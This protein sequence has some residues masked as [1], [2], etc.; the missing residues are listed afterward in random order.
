[1]ELAGRY[2]CD[3]GRARGDHSRQRRATYRRVARGDCVVAEFA[4]DV[5]GAPAAFVPDPRGGRGCGRS[6]WRRP[7]G[8]RGQ[9]GG[10]HPGCC[11]AKVRHAR[12][13]G[14]GSRS[15][16]SS[17]PKHSSTI[18]HQGVPPNGLTLQPVQPGRALIDQCL[19]QPHAGALASPNSRQHSRF[20]RDTSLLTREG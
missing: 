13:I 6:A 2:R 1:M 18:S 3:D 15:S 4:Q 16:W 17:I 12:S 11:W 19:A 7:G 14:T 5:V 9:S 10:R 8:R 20:T